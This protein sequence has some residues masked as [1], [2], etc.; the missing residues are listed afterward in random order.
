L[1]ELATFSSE[2]EEHLHKEIT[3]LKA[4]IFKLE[5]T[6]EEHSTS[7]KGNETQMRDLE[8]EIRAL[9]R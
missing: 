2:K 6:I 7:L 1:A 3:I 5:L 9:K 8:K 4:V